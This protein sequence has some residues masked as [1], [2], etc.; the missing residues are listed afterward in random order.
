[1]SSTKIVGTHVDVC[2][3]IEDDVSPDVDDAERQ[4]GHGRLEQP[5]RQR[6]VGRIRE[7]RAR[8]GADA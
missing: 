8:A 2:S 5:H 1:M 3:L 4:A 7:Q 6:R